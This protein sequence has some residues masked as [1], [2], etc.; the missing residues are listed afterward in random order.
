MSETNRKYYVY[1][2]R[3]TQRGHI[4]HKEKIRRIW[5]QEQMDSKGEELIKKYKA[6]QSEVG[7]AYEVYAGFGKTCNLLL[8]EMRSSLYNVVKTKK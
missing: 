2:V 6:L 5:T 3:V 7:F 1:S 8:D 4:T